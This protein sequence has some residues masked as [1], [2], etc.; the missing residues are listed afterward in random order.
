MEC[1][2]RTYTLEV[3][4]PNQVLKIAFKGIPT[5]GITKSMTKLMLDTHSVMMKLRGL[6]QR[7]HKE[8]YS[9]LWEIGILEDVLT[10]I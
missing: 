7:F 1:N 5:Q 8:K 3:D 2:V 6:P 9:N 4:I 10:G